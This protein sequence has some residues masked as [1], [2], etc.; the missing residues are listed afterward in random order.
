MLFYPKKITNHKIIMLIHHTHSHT[1]LKRPLN[2][3]YSLFVETSQGVLFVVCD[4]MG[5]HA[6]GDVASKLASET[7]VAFFKEKHSFSPKVLLEQCISKVNE[8]VF[9]ASQQSSQLTGMGTT[10]VLA[11]VQKNTLF[12]ANVGDSRLYFVRN[13]A[14]K[15]LS[16]DHSYSQELLNAGI[17]SEEEYKNH[18]RKNE[19]TRAIG[20]RKEVKPTVF[21]TPI[22]LIRGDSILLCTDGLFNMLDDK[23]IQQTL[24]KDATIENK[25][26]QLIENANEAGG[27]DNITACLIE[28]GKARKNRIWKW[29]I[30]LFCQT[31]TSNLESI[32]NLLVSNEKSTD[33]NTARLIN[34]SRNDKLFQFTQKKSHH[35]LQIKKS[36]VSLQSDL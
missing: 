32:H 16:E 23:A 3:D 28:V 20:I 6:K 25:V 15:Q 12:Y 31:K 7:A 4:G 34:K 35:L 13:G 5:G 18:P 8:V 30:G 19:L 22:T 21:D 26:A 36:C 33:V 9:N 11:L 14:I 17:I 29:V 1:G 24:V 10:I 27:N 2:E